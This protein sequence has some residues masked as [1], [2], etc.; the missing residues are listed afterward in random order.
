MITNYL[1]TLLRNFAKNKAY[2]LIN[3]TGL[4]IGMAAAMLIIGWIQNEL[5]MDRFHEK[6]DRIYVMHNHDSDPEGNRWAWNNTPKILAPTLKADYPEVEDA[7]RFNNITF[8][9]TIG[10]KRLN[11]RG[12]FT[13]SGFF[14]LFNFPLVYGDETTALKD[15]HSIVLTEKFAKTL[16]GNAEAMGK[17]IR[18]DSNRNVTVT[19]ILK[20][21]PNNTLLAFDYLLPWDHMDRLGWNDTQWGNNSVRT[22]TLLK[23]GA[24]QQAFD[25]KVRTITI[26]HTKDTKNASTTEVFTQPLSRYYLYGK[27]EDGKLVAGNITT[28]RLFMVLAAFILLIACIN[29][30]NL[31]TARSERRAKEVGIRKVVGVSKSLLITQFLVESV[32][33]SAFSFLVALLIVQVSLSG[34]NQLVGKELFVPYGN[35]SFWLFALG[36]ILITGVVAGSY[37]A[38]YLSSFNPVAVL[39]GTF[40]KQNALVAPRKILVT[41]QFTFAIILI[42]ATIIVYHQIQY[43]LNRDSGYNRNNLVYLFYQGDMDKHYASVRHELLD[44]GSATSVSLSANP[45][46]QRWSDS[47]GFHW[48]GSTKAD[49]KIDF[50]RLGTDADFTKT[51]GIELVE[52]RDIDVYKYPTDSMAL[53]LNEAAVKAMRLKNP[54]GTRIKWIGATEYF[55]VVGVIKDFI[56]ESPFEQTINPMM[57]NGPAGYSPNILHVKLNPAHTTA[58]NL[59]RM[60]KIFKTYNPQYPFEYVFADENYAQK[61]KSAE[62]SGKLAGLFALLTILISCLGLFGLAAYMAESRTKEIGVRKVLGAS[63]WSV[64]HLLSKDFLK[65]VMLSFLIASPI[66]WYAMDKWLGTY[67]YRIDIEWSVFVLTGVLAAVIALLTVSWQA[68]KAA[69]AN[70][71]DSLRDE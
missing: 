27:S 67:T 18:I 26:D 12:A 61:F 29:F 43:G 70:P 10:D 38:F 71:V 36:F 22:Y 5:S 64:T 47:W 62:R 1:R 63:V 14:N 2:S 8:L 46:T 53:L 4:S 3:I 28:V 32:L 33:L 39:K 48:E 56:L 11:S 9:F 37:P 57:V 41:I 50:V 40:K 25:Q 16:F 30:M 54:I 13:D 15:G 52:G 65:L 17:T 58:E 23:P 6:E 69:V 44:N 60:E 68:I 34:F 66:A 19:G 35:L 20:D 7:V 31:S 42:I 21:L 24:S 59:A 45:I 55:H 49:E 51:F